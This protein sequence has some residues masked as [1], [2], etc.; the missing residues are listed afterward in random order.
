MKFLRFLAWVFRMGLFL[1]LLAFALK[2]TDAVTLRFFLDRS[3]QVPLNLLLLGFLVLG[4]ALGL[5]AAMS[6]VFRERR[7]IVALRRE[8]RAL[9]AAA[10]P[11]GAEPVPPAPADAAG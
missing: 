11:A 10:A 7:E 9:S 6:R 8:L 5:L 1:L 3:W 4:A 2:N